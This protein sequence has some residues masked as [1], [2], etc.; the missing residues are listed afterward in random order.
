M[1]QNEPYDKKK[2][3]FQPVADPGHLVMGRFIYFTFLVATSGN[4]YE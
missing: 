4:S 3:P 2:N 1:S